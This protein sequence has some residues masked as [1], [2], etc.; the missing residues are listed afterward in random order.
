MDLMTRRRALLARV[1][2]GGRLPAGY[3]E[4]EY[5]ESTGTQYLNTRY[6]P[7]TSSKIS[8]KMSFKS[9]TPGQLIGI[10]G[11]VGGTNSRFAFGFDLASSQRQ[12][13]WYCGIGNLNT[14][15][16]QN[17]T[18]LHVFTIDAI[19]KEFVVDNISYPVA[20]SDMSTTATFFVLARN[21]RTATEFVSGFL[22]FINIYENGELVESFVPCYRKS[23]SKPGMYD[24]ISNTFITNDGTDEFIVGAD[25]N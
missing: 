7:N 12:S 5:L 20:Y 9:T 13:K 21:R 15:N 8:V 25:I 23:D 3:Q 14:W 22:Y 2:S 17:D 19:N 18:D 10:G 11:G 6:I 4:V 16:G 24:I 1:E